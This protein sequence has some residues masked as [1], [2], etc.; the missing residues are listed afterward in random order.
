MFMEDR[1][2][3]YN[4][5]V[6]NIQRS[7]SMSSRNIFE[8]ENLPL[9]K[10]F[11]AKIENLKNKQINVISSNSDKEQIVK[12][13]EKITLEKVKTKEE[14]NQK[15]AKQYN[16]KNMDEI[17]NYRN[18]YNELVSMYEKLFSAYNE[19]KTK[20]QKMNSETNNKEQ[21]DLK[22]IEIKL[23]EKE[24]ET[25]VKEMEN[26][27]NGLKKFSKMINDSLQI[28][29]KDDEKKEIENSTPVQEKEPEKENGNSE[30][31]SNENKEEAV[32]IPVANL[33][34]NGRKEPKSITEAPKNLKDDVSKASKAGGPAVLAL[35]GIAA[36]AILMVTNPA[37]LSMV[38]A[39][40]LIKAGYDFNKGKKL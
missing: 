30:A 11:E 2:K 1:E 23:S 40:G 3:I 29:E 37:L 14:Y 38:L 20:L 22:Q 34:E 28:P 19:K 36:T 6:A 10:E 7:I 32:S 25:I 9:I 26:L 8:L 35:V 4:D 21:S 18:D 15:L 17:K 13:I 24:Q 12:E 16:I 33:N 5:V 31:K 27:N 39:G